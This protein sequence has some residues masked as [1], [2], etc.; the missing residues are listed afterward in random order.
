ML[1]C[2]S[3]QKAFLNILLCHSFTDLC[4]DYRLHAMVTTPVWQSEIAH[5]IQSH[6]TPSEPLFIYS[7]FWLFCCCCF[8]VFVFCLFFVVVFSGS[9]TDLTTTSHVND[10]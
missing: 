5:N 4:L 3:L 7:L 6:P 8:F 9:E 1:C 2:E 10:A